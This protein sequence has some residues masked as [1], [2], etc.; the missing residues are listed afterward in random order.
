MPSTTSRVAICAKKP[1]RCAPKKGPKEP[2]GLVAP[3]IRC[4]P[5]HRWPRRTP[6]KVLKDHRQG[7]LR[8]HCQG[9][10]GNPLRNWATTRA[11]AAP[12]WMPR[13]MTF[14]TWPGMSSRRCMRVATR[15]RMLWVTKSTSRHSYANLASFLI[16]K[17]K[18]NI[19]LSTPERHKGI[20]KQGEWCSRRLGLHDGQSRLKTCNTSIGS[21]Y[22]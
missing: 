11:I 16:Q 20:E 12:R 2:T 21:L 18:R 8:G 19:S 14:Q 6:R 3:L 4:W 15:A 1:K 13:S 5:P 10:E 22:S 7:V 9:M 17:I